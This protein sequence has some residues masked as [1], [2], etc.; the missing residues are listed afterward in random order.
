MTA[1]RTAAL[2]WTGCAGL[3]AL[4]VA[5]LATGDAG[6]VT[7]ALHATAGWWWLGAAGCAGLAA[8]A[9]SR[10]A[11]AAAVGGL[12][13]CAGWT[14]PG[15]VGRSVGA[16]GEGVLVVG[17]AN[18]LSSNPDVD[19]LLA[20]LAAEDPDV[21]GLIEV[22]AAHG[23]LVDRRF[24]SAR[25]PRRRVIPRPD[26]FGIA[27]LCGARCAAPRELG[28]EGVPWIAVPARVGEATVEVVVAHALPPV[29]A[30]HHAVWREQIGFLA[31]LPGPAVVLADLNLTRHNP[32]FR[33]LCRAGFRDA[34]AEV[35]R[36]AVR[37]WTPWRRGPDLLR[38]D[39]VLVRGPVR[40]VDVRALPHR[41][42]DHRAVV[43]RLAA[44]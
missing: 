28:V 25:W 11:L 38:L 44:P 26:N 32:T 7:T 19:A 35:G 10:R 13:L 12:V 20:E 17:V 40:V 15:T 43:A 8:A 29:T 37:T 3:W 18:V 9:G 42:S 16:R 27:A 33:A 34:F 5:H 6:P 21:V 41:G 36:A 30:A 31:A 24:P 39:H 4:V 22:R 2:A 23:A 1:T 14:V